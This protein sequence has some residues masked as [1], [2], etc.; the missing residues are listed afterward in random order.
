MA[1]ELLILTFSIIVFLYST[2]DRATQ[3]LGSGAYLE[4]ATSFFAALRKAMETHRTLVA[5]TDTD[6]KMRVLASSV[7]CWQ[8][9]LYDAFF[10]GAVLLICAYTLCAVLALQPFA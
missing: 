5:D 6:R 3:V 1:F 10:A 8:C 7:M 4:A 9:V 2:D